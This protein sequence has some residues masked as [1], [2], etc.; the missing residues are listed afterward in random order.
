M[1][2]MQREYEKKGWTSGPHFYLVVGSYKP[3]WDGIWCMSPPTAPGTH[4]GACN[5]STFGIELVGD[6]QSSP[7]SLPLRKLL[8][9]T[10]VALHR[11]AGLGP[12][13]KAHRDCMAGRTCP[14]DALYALLPTLRTQLY[15]RLHGAGIYMA[16]H[17]QAVFEAPTPTARVALSDTARVVEGMRLDIDEVR[18]DGW[19]HLTSGLGFVPIGVLTRME[20]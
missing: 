6:F 2:A 4:A 19:A 5:S 11:W 12:Q 14:G 20:D 15:G 1:L 17:T 3:S 16:R 8:L 7:P 18:P 13:L 10:L 9:D